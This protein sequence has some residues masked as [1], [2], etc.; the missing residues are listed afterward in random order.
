VTLLT[1]ARTGVAK[2]I[3]SSE[4]GHITDVYTPLKKHYSLQLQAKT[5][6]Q[7]AKYAVQHRNTTSQQINNVSEANEEQRD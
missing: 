4:E 6:L 7:E 1:T 3:T 5:K 2:I